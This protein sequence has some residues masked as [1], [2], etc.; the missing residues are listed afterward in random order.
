MK[1]I[2]LAI[3]T[4]GIFLNSCGLDNADTDRQEVLDRLRALGVA[5]EPLVSEIP[6]SAGSPATVLLNLYAAVPSDETVTV[7]PWVNPRR[8][9][10]VAILKPG[11]IQNIDYNADEDVVAGALKIKKIK[12]T[13]NVPGAQNWTLSPDGG[14]VQYGFKIQGSTRT[15][16]VSGEFLAYK[17]GAEQLNWKSPEVSIR[18]PAENGNLKKSEENEIYL[19][20]TKP[21]P[22]FYI[23]AWFASRGEIQSRRDDRTSWTPKESGELLLIATVRG[24]DSLG[25]GIRIIKV[26]AQ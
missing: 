8:P 6:T 22:E 5:P 17:A 19:E 14:A 11:D 13:A 25:F 12:I 15:E 20:Y 2:L 24:Q 9:G 3:A 7:E 10:A 21:Q 16:H 23:P 4:S 1:K 18:L 26:N